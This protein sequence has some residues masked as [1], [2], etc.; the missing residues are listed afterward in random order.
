M[1][2]ISFPIA[3]V[4][5][6][7][8]FFAPCVVPLLPT[9]IAY[10]SGVS[11]AQLREKG[12]GEY[13]RKLL[14]SSIFYILGFSL[15]FVAL[16][17]AAAGIGGLFRQYEFW[18]Q[19]IGGA[20]IILF[21]LQFAGFLHLP[22]FMGTAPVN[23]PSWAAKLGYLRSF[24]IG[25]LF[26]LVWTP[27]VGVVLGSILAIAA[28]GATATKGAMLLFVYSLGISIPFLVVA[29]TLAQVPKYLSF[30]SR[31]I[32]LISRIAGLLLVLVGVLL[33]TDTYKFVNA[34]MF[35]IAFR[36]GYQIR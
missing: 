33:L 5:G 26:A 17:T 29:L 14:F 27:C 21:G 18:I 16:G 34:W 32:G 13:Q 36:L 9:Y 28:V 35:E 1:F 4:G 6:V 11:L 25:I 31:H 20:L 10:V 30:I 22:I 12:I 24:F 19:R 8:S 23:L 3:F 2:D 15:I 7:V